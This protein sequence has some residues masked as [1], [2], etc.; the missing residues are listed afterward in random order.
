MSGSTF[1]TVDQLTVHSTP[2]LHIEPLTPFTYPVA[3]PLRLR[4]HFSQVT[5]KHDFPKEGFSQ[6]GLSQ[7]G[8][9]EE[10]LPEAG[11]EG[12]GPQGQEEPKE[13]R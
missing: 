7:E 5:Q 11:E 2:I 6:E 9:P 3:L 1:S 10:D 13:G 8:V 12:Q 4:F